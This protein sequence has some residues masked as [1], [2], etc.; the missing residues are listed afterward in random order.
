MEKYVEFEVKGLKRRGEKG[1]Q[2]LVLE[3]IRKGQKIK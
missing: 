2:D 3:G 1:R